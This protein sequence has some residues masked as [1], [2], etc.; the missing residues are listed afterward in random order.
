MS[1]SRY[2]LDVNVLIALTDKNHAHQSIALRWWST[3]GLDWGV[4]A[5]TEAGFLRI[6]TNPKVGTHSMD[7]AVAI[8]DDL[9]R[10][11]GYRY[12]PMPNNWTAL[13]ASFRDRIVG[14]QQIT[15]AF[16]LGL[17][18]QEDGVLVTMDK[19]ILYMAGARLNR[20]VLVLS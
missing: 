12:W 10:Q 18:V 13:T 1:S 9:A 14:H 16:L 5:F 20:H 11:P 2:L 7:G 4:C 3:P 6:A 15:D 17:A 19:A 8:L